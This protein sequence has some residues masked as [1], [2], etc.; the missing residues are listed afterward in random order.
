MRV[1]RHG[2]E[3][4]PANGPVILAINHVSHL[5]PVFVSVE[6]P[7]E[8]GWLARSEF[9]SNSLNR[10]YL[11]RTGA[12]ETSRTGYARPTLR[13]ALRRLQRG[14]AVGIF[15]EG[16][17][18]TGEA[19]V[20]LGGAL[21]GGAVWLAARSGAPVIPIVISGT[22]HLNHAGPWLPAKR[23]KLWICAGPPL[24]FTPAQTHG[25]ARRAA[26]THLAETLR[27][28]YGVMHHHLQA[29]TFQHS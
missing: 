26:T 29:P 19:S 6:A 28:L 7:R 22:Q 2:L 12:I 10:A 20:M 11:R 16:E 27:E 1:R 13:H 8:V 5:D 14:E 4:I 9:Y 25:L 17:I 24:I 23:G 18:H 15:P 3:N 21:R